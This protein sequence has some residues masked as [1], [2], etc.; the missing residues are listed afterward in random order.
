MRR[1]GEAI[2]GAALGLALIAAAG[3]GM[4]DL[5]LRYFYRYQSRKGKNAST[6]CGRSDSDF[7]GS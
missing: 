2:L 5:G 6:C 4:I 3:A 1:L 7:S